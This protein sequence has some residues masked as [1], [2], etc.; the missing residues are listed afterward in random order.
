M[1]KNVKAIGDIAATLATI[2]EEVIETKP[3]SQEIMDKLIPITD[4]MGRHLGPTE[5]AAIYA[6]AFSLVFED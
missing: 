6:T 2:I 5:I 3:S 1:S 4:V